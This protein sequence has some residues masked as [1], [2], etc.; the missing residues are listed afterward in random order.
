MSF[1]CQ[2]NLC[3]KRCFQWPK[4]PEFK[5]ALDCLRKMVHH[6]CTTEEL[7]SFWINTVTD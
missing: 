3:V 6:L 1:F 2:K 5:A 4:D 7:L